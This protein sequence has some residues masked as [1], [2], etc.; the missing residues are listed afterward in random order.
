MNVLL[1]KPVA[2]LSSSLCPV[3]EILFH[4]VMLRTLRVHAFSLSLSYSRTLAILP[5]ELLFMTKQG[6][7]DKKQSSKVRKVTGVLSRTQSKKIKNKKKQRKREEKK[8][9]GTVIPQRDRAVARILSLV[10]RYDV[11]ELRMLSL[12]Y[13]SRTLNTKCHCV[14]FMQIVQHNSS[15]QP[16]LFLPG[17]FCISF[18]V[19]IPFG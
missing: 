3:L 6:S 15:S 13:F 4:E 9:E 18:V 8:R 19:G 10:L 7:K 12:F 2:F 1:V 17:L 5:S 16:L 14:I 11:S